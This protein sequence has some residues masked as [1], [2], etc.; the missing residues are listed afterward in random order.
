MAMSTQLEQNH[1][2]LCHATEDCGIIDDIP[3][4]YPECTA[5]GGSIS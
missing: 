5:I 1:S 2:S 4:R 3:E